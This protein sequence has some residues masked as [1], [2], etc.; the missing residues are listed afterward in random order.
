M[1]SQLLFSFEQ[2]EE[3]SLQ[4]YR[5][6]RVL[7]IAEIGPASLCS[8]ILWRYAG[9]LD[10]PSISRH[11][12]SL[13]VHDSKIRRADRPVQI[14]DGDILGHVLA[15]IH[16]PPPK[17]VLAS[18]LGFGCCVSSFVYRRQGQDPFQVLVFALVVGTVATVA[19]GTGASPDVLLLGFMPLAT[20]AAMV[21]SVLGHAML[22]RRISY[23]GSRVDFQEKSQLL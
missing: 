10:A 5:W 16:H 23:Q 14:N 13:P 7:E 22:R 4:K 3:L 18:A 2:P 9:Q 17:L 12:C 21:I 11:V 6:E 15:H 19:Y 20:C 1:N 8:L